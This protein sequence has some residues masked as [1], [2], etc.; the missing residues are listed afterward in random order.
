MV[1]GTTDIR[2]RSAKAVCGPNAVR[3]YGNGRWDFSCRCCNLALLT[4]GL[5][6]S[7]DA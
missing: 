2:A 5:P 6:R 3:C 7:W 4:V 1:D